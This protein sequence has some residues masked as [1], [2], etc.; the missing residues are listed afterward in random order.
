MIVRIDTTNLTRGREFSLYTK[1]VN[2][3]NVNLYALNPA[4]GEVQEI[5]FTTAQN[6]EYYRFDAVAPNFD[7][8]L[9]ADAQKQ[10]VV[11]KIG[12]PIQ[13]FVIGYRPNRTIPY[14]FYSGA[15][16]EIG[17]GNLINA[18]AGFYYTTLTGD[19]A[20]VK[21]LRKEFIVNKNLLKMNYEITMEGGA[22]D[23]TFEPGRLSSVELQ[24][25]ALPDTELGHAELGST[26]PDV[27]IKEL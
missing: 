21:A 16:E 18:V 1:G 23:S 27:T 24:N 26:M 6:G 15:G 3:D 20:I 12:F 19:V 11:K 8:F 14:V 22:L 7:G 17:R 2:A 25:I 5:T 9:L 4:T 10:K 13:S